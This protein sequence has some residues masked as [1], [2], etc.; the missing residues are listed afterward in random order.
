MCI[1]TKKETLTPTFS[2]KICNISVVLLH[3]LIKLLIALSIKSLFLVHL[4]LLSSEFM[5][6]LSRSITF[7]L[8]IGAQLLHLIPRSVSIAL[9]INSSSAMGVRKRKAVLDIQEL[10]S[11]SQ[12]GLGVL[13]LNINNFTECQ[14]QTR[15][16]CDQDGLRQK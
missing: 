4:S 5:G 15:P 9:Y 12:P 10:A 3:F 14:Y 7:Y 2:K 8:L 16:L 1:E 6:L 13:L 11:Y